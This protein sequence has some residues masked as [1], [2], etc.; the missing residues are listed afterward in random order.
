[1]TPARDPF[2]VFLVRG[3]D[4]EELHL[5]H[6]SSLV[7]YGVKGVLSRATENLAT[8]GIRFLQSADRF[9]VRDADIKRQPSPKH[10]LAIK[11][12]NGLRGRH[13]YAGK[14]FLRLGFELGIDSSVQISPFCH[15]FI[16]RQPH[17]VCNTNVWRGKT[18]QVQQTVRLSKVA[19]RER[20]RQRAHQSVRSVGKAT[21]PASRLHRPHPEERALA[22]VSKDGPGL[23]P[24]FETPRRR[25][26]SG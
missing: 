4:S 8:A 6:L 26:S 2:V 25:G 17:T 18:F 16:L 9:L 19:G 11:H 24:S 10:D 13:A 20:V 1:M 22:R 7:E 5:L 3:R 12:G 21:V 23:L 14:N 15:W